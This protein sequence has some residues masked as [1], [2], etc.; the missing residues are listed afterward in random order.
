VRLL[1]ARADDRAR[2]ACARYLLQLPWGIDRQATIEL[3]EGMSATRAADNLALFRNSLAAHSKPAV[4]RTWLWGAIGEA[5]PRECLLGAISDLAYADNDDDRV[6]FIEFLGA[7][8]DHVNREKMTLDREVITVAENVDTKDWSSVVRGL[9]GTTLCMQ[10][11][12][13][14]AGRVSSRLDRAMIAVARAWEVVRLD[15]MGCLI[16]LALM[17]GTG[18]LTAYGLNKLVGEP[19]QFS[20]LPVAL[21][22]SWIAWALVNIRTH[23]SGHETIKSKVRAGLVYFMLL[24][25]TIVAAIVVRAA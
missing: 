7:I 4:L 10:L 12:Q 1:A 17:I 5:H 8:F 25:A 20:W 15:H 16:P 3:L 19:K 9:Y 23:F 24:L 11:P 13:A 18:F 14:D 21:F 2:F 22:W 6:T